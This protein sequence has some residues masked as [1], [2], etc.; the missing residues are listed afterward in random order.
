M[1]K[2]QIILFL[3]LLKKNKL[4]SF[5]NLFGLSLSIGVI[6]VLSNIVLYE[7]SFEDF[8]ENKNNVFR[9]ATKIYSA[10]GSS[11]YTNYSDYNTA[12][13]IKLNSK[14]VVDFVRVQEEYYPLKIKVG[15][16]SFVEDKV[17]WADDSF[18]E[19]F[20]Y[21]IG[22]SEK[23][24]V[25][26][27]P[28]S[29]VLTEKSALKL[30]GEKNVVGK[31]I[32]V[33]NKE[34]IITAVIKGNYDN[35]HLV[36]DYLLSMSTYG[37][38]VWTRMG[39]SFKTYFLLSNPDLKKENLTQLNEKNKENIKKYFE[40]IGSGVS[41]V[42][43]KLERLTDIHLYGAE[44]QEL[45]KSNIYYIYFLAFVIV[46][47]ITISFSNYINLS[48]SIAETRRKEIGIKKVAGIERAKL[49]YQFVTESMLTT[50]ISF[51]IGLGLLVLF[52]ERI[53]SFYNLNL[54]TLFSPAFIVLSLLVVL[55]LGAL[56]GIYPAVYLSNINPVESFNKNKKKIFINRVLVVIQ[57]FITVVLVTNVIV[58]YNQINYLKGKSNEFNSK[59]ILVLKDLSSEI[60]RNSL[61]FANELKAVKSINNVAFSV[62]IP[63]DSFSYQLIKI[64]KEGK[65]LN[66]PFMEMFTSYDY[67]RSLEI[68]V[69]GGTEFESDAGTDYSKSILINETAAKLLGFENPVGNIIDISNLRGAKIIGVIRDFHFESLRSNIKPLFVRYLKYPPSYVFIN[70]S[71][72]NLDE[73]ISDVQKKIKE[74]DDSYQFNYTF[75]DEYFQKVHGEEKELFSILISA[76]LFAIIIS[77]LGLFAL[78]YFVG[79]RKQ[80]E[81]S[82]KKIHGAT[83][84]I[85]IS[86]LIR[87]SM[88]SVFAGILIGIPVSYYL[89]TVWLNYF[90]YKIEL[91]VIYFAYGIFIILIISIS[92]IFPVLLKALKKNPVEILGSE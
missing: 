5:I 14:E 39:I 37:K 59:K 45:K 3:R 69:V 71:S 76:S 62:N 19:V 32:K 26:K 88:N 74:F 22:D 29:V 58:G 87:E 20:T 41:K 15:S 91:S 81:V 23:S 90:A 10:D 44:Y 42:D 21:D 49:R 63:G 12:E 47:I 68:P 7:L 18:F 27:K 17:L 54:P 66:Y 48:I 73:L 35:S 82:I 25:L 85:L 16:K 65:K 13:V 67:F 72:N 43:S 92:S 24:K 61:S 64:T 51:F 57:F 1:L 52:E 33:S 77:I 34:F 36:F 9:F 55:V 28:N 46:I 75:L 84:S 83:T 31:T 50:F 53:T 78:T 80:K 86:E 6:I 40:G 56:A 4:T 11:E 79:N 70:A 38:N 8:N 2:N 60:Q 30:F 89:I